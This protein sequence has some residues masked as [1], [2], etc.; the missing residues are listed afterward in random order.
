[1]RIVHAS[2]I[3][4]HFDEVQISECDIFAYTGDIGDRV[5]SVDDLKKFLEWM[6]AAPAKVRVW[7][8]GNHDHILD[9]TWVDKM[10]DKGSVEGLLALQKYLDAKELIS[11]YN[12]KYLLNRDYVYEGVKFYGSPYSPSFHRERWAFNADR[13]EEIMKHWNKIPSDVNVLLTHTGPLGIMDVVPTDRR[14]DWHKDGHV[15]CENLGEVIKNRLIKL[16][17]HCFGHIHDNYGIQLLKV[18]NTRSVLF[19][20]GA[21]VSNQT[22]IIINKPLI[23]NL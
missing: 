23:I 1:M 19:S 17:L 15:G 6:M 3:H 12:V 21:C 7:I 13:G 18:S 14:S 2:D 10:R 16:K 20:N 9:P 22:K 4:G 11:K 8:P 5:T